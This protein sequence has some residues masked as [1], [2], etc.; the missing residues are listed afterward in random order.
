[1]PINAI[2]QIKETGTDTT[3]QLQQA[4]QRGDHI[5]AYKI[6]TAKS[7]PNREDLILDLLL[8]KK[9]GEYTI[10]RF[11]AQQNAVRICPMN[12]Q[13]FVDELAEARNFWTFVAIQTWTVYPPIYSDVYQ[14]IQVSI[15]MLRNDGATEIIHLFARDEVAERQPIAWVQVDVLQ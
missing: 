13:K 8:K 5:V 6:Y 4:L 2:R 9:T 7:H 3:R 12:R 1:M 11:W 14:A 15:S 10:Y